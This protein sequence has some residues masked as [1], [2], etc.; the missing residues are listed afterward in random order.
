M[1]AVD[2]SSTVPWATPEDLEAR[3]RLLTDDEKQRA[4]ALIDDAMS[5]IKDECPKWP[6]AQ[7]ESL[8]RIVCQMVHRAMLA[9]LGDEDAI[10]VSNASMTT[11]PFSQALTFTN[12]GGDLYLTKAERR[13]LAGRRGRAYE[14][15]LLA[16]GEVAP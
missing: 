16:S 10:G 6:S 1:T 4:T 15:D 7:L 14:V 12:P 9:P 3:W 11:G 13:A 2:P 5:L 8:R